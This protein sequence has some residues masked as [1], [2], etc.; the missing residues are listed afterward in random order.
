MIASDQSRCGEITTVYRLVLPDGNRK[1]VLQGWAIVD[2]TLAQ[3]WS[4]VELSLVAGA[5]QSFVQQISQPYYVQ[6]PVVPLPPAVLLQPQTHAGTL[7]GGEGRV[8]G[9]VPL[10]GAALRAHRRAE[11]APALGNWS[12]SC[13]TRASR[14]R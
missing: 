11:K 14:R 10:T 3:D 6:R 5:P 4:N 1:A 9:T 2:N 12:T 7:V 8:R 13:L